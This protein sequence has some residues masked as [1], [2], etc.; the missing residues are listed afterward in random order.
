MVVLRNISILFF[1]IIFFG[2]IQA[3][4]I[5]KDDIGKGEANGK[6]LLEAINNDDLQTVQKLLEVQPDLVNTLIYRKGKSPDIYPLD[7]AISRK[8]KDIAKFLITQSANP[9]AM[10]KYNKRVPLH[11]TAQHGYDDIISLLIKYGANPNGPSDSSIHAPIADAN[12]AKIAKLLIGFGANVNFPNKKNS[13]P[14]HRMAQYGKIEVAN[15]LISHGANVNAQDNSGFAPLHHAAVGSNMEFIALLLEHGADINIKNNKGRT[16][17][18]ET[19]VKRTDSWA[20]SNNPKFY[21]T[22]T[23]LLSNDSDYTI[24]DVVWA[25]DMKKIRR[26]LDTN[27]NLIHSQGYWGEPL[28]FCAIHSGHSQVVEYLIQKGVDINRVGRY[29]EPSLH[30]AAY[31]GHKD[32]ASLLLKKGVDVN[33]K[34]VHGELALHWATAKGYREIVELLVEAGTEVN[35]HTNTPR[36]DVDTL[37]SGNNA[38]V[39]RE[40]LRFLAVSEKQEKAT[41]AGSGLQIWAHMRLAFA[42]GDTPLHSAAQWGYKEIVELLL[43][44]G[45]DVNASNKLGQTPLHYAVVFQHVDVVKALL[46]AGAN[47]NTRMLDGSTALDLALKVKNEELIGLL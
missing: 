44:N 34:G 20:A 23:L 21:E 14:L 39:V 35:T 16:P 43:S 25:G 46:G 45:A 13:T 4:E 6:K 29:K 30:A 32:V 24:E 15:I 41:A 11:S 8:H 19:I 9:D 38:D 37:P 22:I 7:Y 42:G 10:N 33:R 3:V 12:N 1:S 40:C 2:Q 27:P 36:V 26:L 28:L 31:S 18:K 47:P 5:E 17:L